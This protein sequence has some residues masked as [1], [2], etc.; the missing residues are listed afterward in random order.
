MEGY[1]SSFPETRWTEKNLEDYARKIAEEKN[2][3]LGKLVQPL[4]AVLT[5]KTV[6]PSVFEILH[7]LGK[8]KSLK[9]LQKYIS[10]NIN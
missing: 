3:K 7:I 9:R 5:G 8:D 1:L 10:S 6:S 4:R 2:L